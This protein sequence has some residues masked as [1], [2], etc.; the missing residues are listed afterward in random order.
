MEL[1]EQD[2]LDKLNFYSDIFIK[3]KS[4]KINELARTIDQK[5]HFELDNR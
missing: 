4:K 3:H 5:Y 1:S 2:T